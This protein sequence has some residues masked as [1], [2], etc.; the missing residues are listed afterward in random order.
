[1][2]LI[3]SAHHTSDTDTLKARIYMLHIE[4][5]SVKKTNPIAARMLEH[6][7]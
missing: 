4:A 5:S 1:M 7:V 2:S 3:P 6:P